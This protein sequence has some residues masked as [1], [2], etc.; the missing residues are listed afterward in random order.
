ME[1]L[2]DFQDSIKIKLPRRKF[3]FLINFDDILMTLKPDDRRL[4][5]S[6]LYCGWIQ[7]ILYIS[8][9]EKCFRKRMHCFFQKSACAKTQTRIHFLE[10]WKFKW[11]ASNLFS[12]EKCPNTHKF[13]FLQAKCLKKLQSHFLQTQ[14]ANKNYFL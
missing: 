7:Q 13:K 5:M 11:H 8:T 3:L 12:S 1:K 9:S 14:T 2:F 4:F 10:V 6:F